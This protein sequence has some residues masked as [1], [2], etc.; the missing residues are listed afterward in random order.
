MPITFVVT[1]TTG[2]LLW[3]KQSYVPPI[4]VCSFIAVDNLFKIVF[5]LNCTATILFNVLDFKCNNIEV[6]I[7]SHLGTK[8]TYVEIDT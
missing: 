4:S 6:T 3:M 5:V 1:F 2:V 7:E 8:Q